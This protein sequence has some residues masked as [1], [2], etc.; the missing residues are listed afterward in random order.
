MDNI[1]IHF[2]LKFVMSQV[3]RDQHVDIT[4][5]VVNLTDLVVVQL[6][7][8]ELQHVVQAGGH[9]RQSVVAQ[10]QF[11]HPRQVRDGVREALQLVV[12]EIKNLEAL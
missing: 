9:H 11:R 8:V 1:E 2:Y 4:D 10:V 7:V 3:K 12:V 6:Q 5:P